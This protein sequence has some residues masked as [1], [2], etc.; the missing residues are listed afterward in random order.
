MEAVMNKQE[1]FDTV[2][3]H[4]AKQKTKSVLPRPHGNDM[5][6]VYR[7]EGGM[8]CA[9]G[10]LIPDELYDPDMEGDT[11]DQLA[12]LNK[13]PED[14][15]EHVS[16][17]YN[18]QFAHDYSADIAELKSNLRNSASLFDLNDASI[19]NITEWNP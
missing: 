4:L 14:L 9:V 8:K 3:K 6:C 16:L 19:D 17:L 1:I 18:L 15:V 2:V 12:D 7:G 11:V 5:Q 10:C 13:L